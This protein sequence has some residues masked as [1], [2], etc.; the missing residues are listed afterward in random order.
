MLHP[1]WEA[2]PLITAMSLGS[3]GLCLNPHLF[4]PKEW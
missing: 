3:C 1:L 2:T 4:V